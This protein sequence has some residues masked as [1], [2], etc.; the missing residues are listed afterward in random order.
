M[1]LRQSLKFTKAPFWAC[2]RYPECKGAHGAH[3]NG[4]PLGT[5]A[6]EETK[7][8]RQIA[9][10]YLD[11]Q[12][13]RKDYFQYLMDILGITRDEAH[14]ALLDKPKLLK[15]IGKCQFRHALNV[16][17]MRRHDRSLAT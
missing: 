13:G 5:P 12:F 16:S 11:A 7:Q 8:L 9:H 4:K 14:V 17:W 2:T 15:V 1:V 3:P 10:T 6:N